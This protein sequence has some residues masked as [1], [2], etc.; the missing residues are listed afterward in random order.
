MF[1]DNPTLITDIFQAVIDA[2]PKAVEGEE[3][4]NVTE[5]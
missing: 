1:D 3:S 4:G 2:Q 5:G